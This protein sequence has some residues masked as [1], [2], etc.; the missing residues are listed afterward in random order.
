MLVTGSG[1]GVLITVTTNVE[2]GSVCPLDVVAMTIEVTRDVEAGMEEAVTTEV[3]GGGVVLVGVVTAVEVGNVEVVVGGVEVVNGVEVVKGVVVVNGVVGF[4]GVVEVSE[5]MI[6]RLD[7][8]RNVELGEEKVLLTCSVGR[9]V[10]GEKLY[11]ATLSN[12]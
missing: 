9:H 7:R 10:E 11:A 6:R 1:D 5:D 2:G 3:T 8:R 12:L 4:N